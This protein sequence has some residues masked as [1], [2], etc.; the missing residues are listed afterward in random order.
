MKVENYRQNN[1]TD[2]EFRRFIKRWKIVMNWWTAILKLD[3]W[4]IR[5]EFY[6]EPF[7]C[8]TERDWR[9]AA[10]TTAAW[11]YAEATIRIDAGM[12]FEKSD[13]EF[14]ELVV[15]ELMHIKTELEDP[16]GADHGNVSASGATERLCTD[17]ARALIRAKYAKS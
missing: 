9:T 7:S 12:C 17:M 5:L 13:A 1:M 11:R 14:E 10:E 15:H 8:S 2:T 4:D 3:E 16:E 6:R